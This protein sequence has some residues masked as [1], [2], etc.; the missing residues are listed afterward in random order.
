MRSNPVAGQN[1]FGTAVRQRAPNEIAAWRY[2]AFALVVVIACLYALPNLYPPDYALAI[3]ADSTEQVV[4]ESFLGEAEA[5]LDAAGLTVKG[6]EMTERAGR[7]GALLRLL[8]NEA[9]LRA[10]AV[11]E[12]ALNPPGE[13]R[14]YIIALSLA[15]TTP[16]WLTDIGGKPMAKGLDLAGGIHFVLQVD[17]VEALAKRLGDELQKA[18]DLPAGGADPLSK[19]GRRRDG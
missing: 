3:S 16:Q 1:L 6:A 5:L 11:L 17:M 19:P 12:E 10:S 2:V 7:P 4:D 9:Q 14:R 13:E 8:H 18:K 15:S